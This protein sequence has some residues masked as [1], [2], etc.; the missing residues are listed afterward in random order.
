MIYYAGNF[1]TSEGQILRL[2]AL[3]DTGSAA[4]F[5][6]RNPMMQGE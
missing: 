3:L 1:Q 5:A 4:N 6:Q 2:W